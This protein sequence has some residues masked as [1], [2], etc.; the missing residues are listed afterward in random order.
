MIGDFE[1]CQFDVREA[2]AHLPKVLAAGE[3]DDAG[4]DEAESGASE[5]E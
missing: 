4:Q 1:M 5:E 3:M 2:A